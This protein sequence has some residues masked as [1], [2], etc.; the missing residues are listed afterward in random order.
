MIRL[1]HALILGLVGA[2]I[3]HIAILL[4]LPVVSEKDAWSRLAEAGDLYKVV[5][6]SGA[7]GDRRVLR[8]TDPYFRA[9]ACRF[10]LDDGFIH[11]RAAGR[12]PFWSVSIYDRSGRNIYSFND[13]ATAA[14][15][16]D[17][18]VL[19]PLQMVDL[20]KDLPPEYESSIF[21]EA[22]IEQGIVVMHSFVPDPSWEPEISAFLKGAT[23]SAE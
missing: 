2:G 10:D 18:L 22:D 19:T 8:L 15:D 7:V 9:A 16:L 20:R 23:C 13:R 3:V 17:L 14:P 5:P 21:V 6:V 12:V 1:L 4:L 11:I